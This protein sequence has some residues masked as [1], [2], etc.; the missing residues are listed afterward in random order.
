MANDLLRA[1]GYPESY[2]YKPGRDVVSWDGLN[3]WMSIKRWKGGQVKGG[4][5]IGR[6]LIGEVFIIRDCQDAT[7][8]NLAILVDIVYGHMWD[9]LKAPH[10]FPDARFAVVL[11]DWVAPTLEAR[12]FGHRV[13][14]VV[15]SLPQDTIQ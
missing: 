12:I 11:A 4:R 15:N 6:R 10:L 14:F 5:L 8:K 7:L 2:L 9:F 13:A 1:Y 3:D